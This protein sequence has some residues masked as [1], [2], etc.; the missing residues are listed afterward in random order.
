MIS[1]LLSFVLVVVLL[2]SGGA[3]TARRYHELLVYVGF[4]HPVMLRQA[5][6]TFIL[7][8][9]FFLEGFGLFL[10]TGCP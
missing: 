8:S 3:I 7:P 1:L 9:F 10:Y 5:L 6:L 4:R 2:T